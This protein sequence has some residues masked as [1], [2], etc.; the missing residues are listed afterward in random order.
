MIHVVLLCSSDFLLYN[1]VHSVCEWWHHFQAYI[2]PYIDETMGTKHKYWDTLIS[3][4]CFHAAFED[5]SNLQLSR[6]FE[7]IPYADKGV[8][9]CQTA[10]MKMILTRCG[11][12]LRWKWVI[13]FTSVPLFCLRCGVSVRFGDHHPVHRCHAEE[14]DR[15]SSPSDWSVAGVY[16]VELRLKFKICCYKL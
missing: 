15:C 2:R 5:W 11:F 7:K 13:Q 10:V 3:K 12:L 4:S 6:L 1:C 14:E 9:L 8:T 16:E